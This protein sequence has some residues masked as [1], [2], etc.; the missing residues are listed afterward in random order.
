MNDWKLSGEGEPG[1][2]FWKYGPRRLP[3]WRLDSH[4]RANRTPYEKLY[5][6]AGGLGGLALFMLDTDGHHN[7]PD[8]MQTYRWA[9]ETYFP[10]DLYGEG[11]PRGWHGYGVINISG[12]S[13]REY[14]DLAYHAGVALPKPRS[15]K[16]TR[17]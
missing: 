5:V 9:S 3:V 13:V 14:N 15:A 10:G 6:T 8:V 7:E 12:L 11:S 2:P 1:L 4:F 16:S 17:C